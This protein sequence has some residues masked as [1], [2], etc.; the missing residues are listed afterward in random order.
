[1]NPMRIIGEATNTVTSWLTQ[2]LYKID[3]AD[4]T[5]ITLP[6]ATGT[7]FAFKFIV[8]VDMTADAVIQVASSSDIMAGVALAA[9]GAD[10]SVSGWETAAD[11]D[12]IT[13]NGATS[14]GLAG[15]VIMLT[16]IGEGLW[17]VDARLRQTG[18]E[19]TPFSAAV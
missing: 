16:D 13:L 1:M 5:V 2:A 11:T 19:A 18:T 6:D 10:D 17:H 7:G 12:T 4:G 15:D 9:G 3:K 14:G 8:G